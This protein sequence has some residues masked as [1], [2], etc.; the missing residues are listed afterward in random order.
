MP[1]EFSRLVRSFTALASFLVLAAC[2]GGDGSIDTRTGGGDDGGDGGGSGQSITITGRVTFDR[3]PFQPA[4]GSGLDAANPVVSPAREVVVQAI[5]NNSTLATTTTDADGKYSLRV[6]ANRN[7]TIR[8]SARMQ[9]SGSAPTWNFSVRNNTN[10]DAVYVMQLDAFDSGAIDEIRDLHASSGWSGSGYTDVRAAAPFAILDTVYSAKQL[11][12][13]A[14]PA[15]RFPELN[16][17]WSPNNRGSTKLCPDDGDIVTSFYFSDPSERAADDCKR[18]LPNG[19]YILGDF[20]NG[21][22][23]T[24]EFDAHVIAHE[25]GHYFEDRFSRSDS[26]GGE[27]GS[28]DLLDMRVAFG[29]GWGNA[30]GAMALSDP[31][32]RDSSRGVSQDGGFN[33]ENGTG[34]RGWFSELSVGKVLWDI[35][36]TT[37]EPNDNVALGFTPIY[38]AMTGPQVNTDALTSIF[39]FAAALS[40]QSG[41]SSSTIRNLLSTEGI[42]SIDQ[43]G[44]GESNA[45]GDPGFTSVYT[46]ITMDQ[47]VAGIC[48]TNGNSVGNKLGNRRFLRFVKNG[49]GLVTILATGVAAAGVPGSA[50]A[51]DP[52]IVV[53][54]RGIPLSFGVGPQGEPIGQS[55][56]N[57]SEMISQVQLAAGTYILEVY[58]NETVDPLAAVT[59]PRCMTVSISGT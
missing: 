17:F 26:I 16:L 36:D 53:H 42:N 30:F 19:I 49:T 46:E 59:T 22:G 52:D 37:V 33:L 4:V 31:E 18:D 23:D 38:R 2:G 48:S 40:S 10:G 55:S 39:S 54:Q 25:F 28:M 1:Q 44:A 21:N 43:F 12:L 5:S 57:G 41:V 56:V 35:F 58:A 45:G 13:G 50:P 34:A 47:P 27:H 24:D 29:E 8:A 9:K 14:D 3:L 32:Y 11:I 6:P 51:T 7:M 15:A 20:A